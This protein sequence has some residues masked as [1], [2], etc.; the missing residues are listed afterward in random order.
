MIILPWCGTVNRDNC[1]A[2]KFNYG[3]Y[4]QC[5]KVKE[6]GGVYCK[7][8]VKKIDKN[9]GM[10]Q[11]GSVEDRLECGLLDYVSPCGRKAVPFVN[12]MKRLDISKEQVLE[13]A[14]L[15]DITIPECHFRTKL[16]IHDSNKG[17]SEKRKRG[18]PRKIREIVINH[19]MDELIRL[20]LEQQK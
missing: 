12:I 10:L 14:K 6:G 1:H 4:T 15:L 7:Q 9:G 16:D 3:L 2:L 19:D 5:D 8:C 18:R 17:I 20:I 11:Y 13:E